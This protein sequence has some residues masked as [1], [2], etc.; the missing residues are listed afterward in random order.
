M[1]WFGPGSTRPGT[2]FPQRRNPLRVPAYLDV[3]IYHTQQAAEK[4]TKAFLVYTDQPF[5]RTHDLE[6]LVTLAAE[7]ESA[8]DPWIEVADSLTPYAT[9]YRYPTEAMEPDVEEFAQALATA[10]QFYGMVL[11]LI[12]FEA[13][14]VDT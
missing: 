7:A 9:L 6:A 3:A 14:P 5:G 8:L 4:E 13:H 2:T 12:P 10:N 11:T 1:N